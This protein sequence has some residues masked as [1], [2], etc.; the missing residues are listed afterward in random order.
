M[1][2]NILFQNAVL[3]AEE[4]KVKNPLLIIRDGRI[5]EIVRNTEHLSTKEDI[6]LLHFQKTV[7]VVPGFIDLHIHGA[8][9]SDFMDGTEEA[10]RTIQENLP[11]E[12]TTSFLAATM[13]QGKEKVISALQQIN[14]SS[15]TAAGGAEL[16]GVHLE[17]PFI[18]RK[19]AGAQPTQEIVLPS[20]ELFEEFQGA[21]G[22]KI[23]I[24]TLA[25]EEEK[26]EELTNHLFKNGV[27]ASIG[28]S[29]ATGEE[30]LRSFGK[31]ISHATHLFNGM[32]GIHHRD[33]GAAG[34]V[35]L[36]PDV[37]AE[38]I[39]DGVHIEPYM[40]RLIYQVKKADKLILI[41]DAIR[42]KGMNKGIY[43]LGGQ[44]VYVGK[45]A[46]LEDGTL[47]G[48]ILPMNEAIQNMIEFSGCSFEEAI[49]MASL[50]LLSRQGQTVTKAV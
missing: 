11:A 21:A 28:H 4:E 41:T 15:G 27:I 34:A 22:G 6:E 47:A 39:A 12:G 29:N 1:N 30:A 17:G 40:L 37:S 26:G 19:K 8:A 48:S 9:G 24:V 14:L 45:E 16:L 20:I 46:R 25:P 36:D 3:Y 31:G 2:K 18:S 42:A 35:L 44:E 50:N 43:E 32:R 38:I 33:I 7:K 13:T 23:S 5:S 10:I 49:Q